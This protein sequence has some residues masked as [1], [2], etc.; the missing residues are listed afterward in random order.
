MFEEL[1]PNLLRVFMNLLTPFSES[2]M[3][4]SEQGHGGVEVTKVVLELANCV[5][6][7]FHLFLGLLLNLRGNVVLEVIHSL[8]NL[9]LESWDLLRLE[10]RLRLGEISHVVS[11]I[12]FVLLVN[13]AIEHLHR[14][15]I[16]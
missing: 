8:L 11:S 16:G 5:F 4:M 15:A 7:V 14:H 10:H 3:M 6:E 1:E 2:S 13:V 9:F 12:E